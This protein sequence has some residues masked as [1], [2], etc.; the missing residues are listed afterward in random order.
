MP[1]SIML[2]PGVAVKEWDF[3]QSISAA[4]IST[5]AIVAP[6]I[7]GPVGETTLISNESNLVRTFG[8]PDDD[9]AE[10]W[11]CAKN[12][13]EYS[14]TLR[15][16]RVA[17]D[18]AKNS[19]TDGTGILIN[20]ESDWEDTYANGEGDVG[21]FAGRYP[22]ERG[23]SIRVV[24]ADYT[25]FTAIDINTFKL[26]SPGS[27]Y[28]TADDDGV[29]VSFST[30][31]GAGG[32]T[33]T[34]TLNV[35]DD[36]VTG[37][38]IT[39]AGTGYINTP[40]V[41]L[42]IPTG[43]V[44]ADSATATINIW[45]FAP[46]FISIPS[47]STYAS[48]AG[49]AMD[50]MHI[51]VVDADGGIT[52]VAGTVI[53]RYPF[54]SKAANA[55]YDDGTTS[56]YSSVLKSQSEYVYHM[57]HP[58]DGTNWGND[59]AGTTFTLL[60]DLYDETLS[61]GVSDNSTTGITDSILQAGWSLFR[62]SSTVDIGILITGPVGNVVK[63]YITQSVAEHRKDC[64]A[65]LSPNKAEVVSNVGNETKDIIEN[66]NVL[67]SS[68][69]AVMDCNWKYQLDAYNNVF[70]W[71]PL[72]GDIAGLIARVDSDRDPWWSPAGYNRGHIKNVVKMAWNPDNTE[73]DE[74]YSNGI[75]PALVFAGEG[76]MLFGDK[77]MLS[78]DSSFSR[79]NVRRL[80]IVLRKSLSE[81][82]KYQLF[83]FNDTFTRTRFVQMVEPF[84]RDIKGRRGI[85][86]FVVEC[87]EVN[88]TPAVI[89][90]NAFVADI[91]IKPARSINY[92]TLNLLSVG[93]G[94]DFNEIVSS[95]N[96][97]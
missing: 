8:A 59:A 32:I 7:W 89:D 23:N 9:V 33:A 69:Y 12:F 91:I 52:G 68:S 36:V 46:F 54:V 55:K 71:I 21:E 48:D 83:E 95:F 75:N 65:C 43:G 39:N 88:N 40:T 70:R 3:S 92:I 37:I 82:A 30:P 41:T 80:F 79:I 60:S 35:V 34:G 74:L 6:F 5:G 47:T 10:F 16:I 31:D 28:T 67:T 73:R 14:R 13:L 57:D 96:P 20:T 77:T 29:D 62:N 78:K 18:A 17:D 87:S 45:E 53:E 25:V 56:Y 4:A 97:E 11:F 19:T 38:T 93:S 94:V 22:G 63:N 90:N 2:S 1:Q 49:G 76:A 61:G 72:N 84:L 44:L 50:E 81:A 15:V 58:A 51:A 24:M 27:A 26:T 86:D 42:P 85:T 66:R 64:I